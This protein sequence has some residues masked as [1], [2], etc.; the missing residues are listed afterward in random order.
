MIN[1]TSGEI[2]V[3]QSLTGRGRTSPYILMVRAQDNGVRSLFSDVQ[4]N[5]LVGDV[6]LNDGI[7][8]FVR[9]TEDETAYILEV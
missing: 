7:P 6:V 5:V 2:K 8:M 1:S 9:P 4:V 3:K